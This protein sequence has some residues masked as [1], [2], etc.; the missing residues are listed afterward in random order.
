MIDLT[1]PMVCKNGCEFD[2]WKTH[3]GMIL[4]QYKHPNGCWYFG[5]WN[6]HNGR[7]FSGGTDDFDLINIPETKVI[8][9]W[10]NVTEICMSCWTERDIAEMR[11]SGGT[12]AKAIPLRIE[13]TEREGQEPDVKITGGNV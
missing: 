2:Y 12:I 1:K 8:E 6:T 7:L 3:D 5:K 10:A 13:I 4:G 9:V 11:A